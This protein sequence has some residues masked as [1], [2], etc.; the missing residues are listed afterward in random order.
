M[1]LN[2]PRMAVVQ[3]CLGLSHEEMEDAIYDNQT[4]R[5]FIGI[6]LNIEAAPDVTTLL[7]FRLLLET[8]H[9]TKTIF[10]MINLHLSH[11]GLL[12][13]EGS[14]VDTTLIATPS[15]AKNDTGERDPEMHQTKKG[16]Q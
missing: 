16:N 7:K 13:R 1:V 8:N 4:C 6:D 3:Q 11:K 15:S 9:L 2:A 14:I 12:M 5:R 10:N